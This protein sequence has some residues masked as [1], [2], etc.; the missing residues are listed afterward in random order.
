MLY[1]TC[2]GKEALCRKRTKSPANFSSAAFHPNPDLEKRKWKGELKIESS[3]FTPR[4]NRVPFFSLLPLLYNAVNIR[5]PPQS[6]YWTFSAPFSLSRCRSYWLCS[7]W[8]LSAPTKHR[9]S[10]AIRH[11]QRRKSSTEDPSSTP[12]R[13]RPL[14]TFLLLRLRFVLNPVNVSPKLIWNM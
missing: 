2:A 13:N 7:S 4:S 5:R 3:C 9:V 1:N 6:P 14:F 10:R 12:E 11:P 8:A